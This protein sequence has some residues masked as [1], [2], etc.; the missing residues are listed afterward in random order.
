MDI[1]LTVLTHVLYLVVNLYKEV[2]LPFPVGD[3]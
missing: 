1:F 2:N 3:H